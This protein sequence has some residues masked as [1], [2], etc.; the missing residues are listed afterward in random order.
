MFPKARLPHTPPLLHK[1]PALF[2]G[3]QRRGWGI[4]SGLGEFR[5][6]G[7]TCQCPG[8]GS[9]QKNREPNQNLGFQTLMIFVTALMFV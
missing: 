1:R 3:K 5:R 7:L 4:C 8:V 9:Y 2:Q 6:L